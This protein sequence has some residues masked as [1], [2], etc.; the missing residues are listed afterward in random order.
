LYPYLSVH[1]DDEI[2]FVNLLG[3]QNP[4]EQEGESLLQA[5]LG[6][7]AKLLRALRQLTKVRKTQVHIIGAHSRL[8]AE[9]Y[10]R[11]E[12]LN[13]FQFVSSNPDLLLENKD[14]VDAIISVVKKEDLTR[15]ELLSIDVVAGADVPIIW[16]VDKTAVTIDS[17]RPTG[18]TLAIGNSFQL[19]D[20]LFRTG[21][22]IVPELIM[23]LQSSM[24]P[25]V[26]ND[27]SNTSQ[28]QLMNFPFH[29][30][31]ITGDH[32]PLKARLKAP[33]ATPLP[34]DFGFMQVQPN[35]DE[36]N[37]GQLIVGVHIEGRIKPYF[38][39]R[40]T[41]EDKDL[42]GRHNLSYSLDSQYIEQVVISDADLAIPARDQ[43]GKYYPVGFNKIEGSMYDAN[44]ELISNLLESMIDGEDILHIAQKTTS[45]TLIDQQRFY[46]SETYYY[47][48]L[49]GLPISLLLVSYIAYH[50]IRKRKYAT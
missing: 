13:R 12:Q 20:Y 34:L 1:D 44:T 33:L 29:P 6:F 10:N 5:Q 18:S 9:G 25:Q 23:D 15:E 19:E 45:L 11:T 38:Q 16:M 50:W 40:L 30:L 31:I 43:R 49:L 36:Y 42:L 2:I 39:N 17:L 4:G 26:V 8:L 37:A 46:K 21:I 47:F 32:S 3:N 28:T 24:I 7:E 27:G 14:S 41:S 35:P 22:R 48:L